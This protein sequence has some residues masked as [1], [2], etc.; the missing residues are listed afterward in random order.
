MKPSRDS[1]MRNHVVCRP[2]VRNAI[3]PLKTVELDCLRA[4]GL[5]LLATG[6]SR[7]TSMVTFLRPPDFFQVMQVLR[8]SSQRLGFDEI[9]LGQVENRKSLRFIREPSLPAGRK[10]QTRKRCQEI[11]KNRSPANHILEGFSSKVRWRHIDQGQAE[12]FKG[13][14]D[15]TGILRR[16]FQPKI[17]ILGVAWLG[18]LHGSVAPNHQIPDFLTSEGLEQFF[19]IGVHQDH[20]F[21]L[22]KHQGRVPKRPGGWPLH[23][24]VARKARF[25]FAWNQDYY[26]APPPNQIHGGSLDQRWV[27]GQMRRSWG[28]CQDGP[29]GKQI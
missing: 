22:S 24:G 10:S 16:G 15:P 12:L 4:A 25:E 5:A 8:S 17:Q 28:F 20:V 13:L 26:N 19:E 7:W 27:V 11:K 21:G 6:A 2:A 18:I 23:L 3:L 14:H 9:R 1:F 29:A